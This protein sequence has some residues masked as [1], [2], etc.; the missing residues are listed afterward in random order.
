MSE[1]L[2]YALLGVA[3]GAVALALTLAVGRWIGRWAAVAIPFLG[4][5]AAIALVVNGELRYGGYSRL[6]WYAYAIFL[7][8][9]MVLGGGI[10]L[11]FRPWRK[12]AV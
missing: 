12:R 7:A 10:G 2:G 8:L 4:I 6:D 11:S 5:V 9:P 3:M 1:I